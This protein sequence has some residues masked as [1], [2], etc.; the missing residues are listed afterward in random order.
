MRDRVLTPLVR[1]GSGEGGAF[2]LL[3]ADRRMVPLQ[4]RRTELE[5]LR[6]WCDSEAPAGVLVLSGPAG[7]GK[8]RLGL[9]SGLELPSPWAAGWLRPGQAEAALPAIVDC[10]DPALIVIDDAD[11][12]SEVPRLLNALAGHSGQPRVRLLL[13]TRDGAGLLF[14]L[15]PRVADSARWLVQDARVLQLGV[16]GG[17]GDRE[18]WYAL[19]VGHFARERGVLAPSA[20][21]L[22]GAVGAGDEPM[23]AL[24]A[25]ALLTVLAASQRSGA[26]R[27]LPVDQVIEELFS[28]EQAWWEASASVDRWELSGLGA[29]TRERGILA[30][31]VRG[32]AD[33][34]AAVRVLRR[35]PDLADAPEVQVRNLA[36]WVSGRYPSG[37]AGVRIKP[38]MFGDWFVADRLTRHPALATSL[39]SDMDATELRW[40]LAV[41]TRAAGAFP[42]VLSVLTQAWQALDRDAIEMAIRS[43]VLYHTAQLGPTSPPPWTISE[44]AWRSWV[45]IGR[46]TK[47]PAKRSPS[48]GPWPP[49]TPPAN[50]TSLS[51]STSP[52]SPPPWTISESAWRSWVSIGRL[53]KP[54][55]KRSPCGGPWPPTTP[56]TSPT[57]PRP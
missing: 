7:V 27:R 32:A 20:A 46:L 13:I 5:I 2:D 36:R 47:P 17:A 38:D 21:S 52:T 57:S 44:S 24:Q 1:E 55:A 33:E 30:L 6:E 35:V 41:L 31:A 53:T 43:L 42:T 50:A 22:A 15:R 16:H 4:G 29:E 14:G 8:T 56:P 45:S 11:A 19:A 48:G 40:A 23:L 3:V 34:D 12:R 37:G 9:E 49:T 54:P 26:V 39:L 18:R 10:G 25:R 51:P 28:H